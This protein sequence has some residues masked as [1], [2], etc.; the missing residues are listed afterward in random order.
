MLNRALPPGSGLRILIHPGA[1]KKPNRWPAERFGE[2]GE[3]LRAEGHSVATCSGPGEIGL[4]GAMDRAAGRPF[5]RLPGLGLR[6]LAAA[7]AAADLVLV[8]DTGVL[9][10]AAAS[11]PA[12]LALFGP[13]DPELWCPATPRVRTV[14]A[15]GGDLRRLESAVVREAAV[16]WASARGDGGEAPSSL[17]SAPGIGA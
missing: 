14:R 4:L 16:G 11:A 3:A 12:V 17:Q 15:P 7:F 10:L 9:H 6:E 13:T 2:V 5:P 8:N 1:G